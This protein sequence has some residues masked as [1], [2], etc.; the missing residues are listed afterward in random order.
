M[1]HGLLKVG[2]FAC[3]AAVGPVRRETARTESWG[4]IFR[5]VSVRTLSTRHGLA[6]DGAWGDR[7]PVRRTVGVAS[8]SRAGDHSGTSGI[9]SRTECHR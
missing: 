5:F 1:I 4:W 2:N 6:G 7:P 9:H 8:S 3:G